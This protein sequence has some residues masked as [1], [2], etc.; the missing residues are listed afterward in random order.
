MPGGPVAPAGIFL[1]F[2]LPLQLLPLPLLANAA[3]WIVSRPN[4][5]FSFD[6]CRAGG[7][8]APAPA[9]SG[10]R[11]LLAVTSTLRL[12]GEQVP[13]HMMFGA[14]KPATQQASMVDRGAAFYNNRL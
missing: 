9:G 3:K 7:G 11:R 14:S 13:A 2:L 12:P 4:Q 8:G 10:K 5:H 6:L 1:L